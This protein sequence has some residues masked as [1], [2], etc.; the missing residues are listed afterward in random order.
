MAKAQ[1]PAH[2]GF[3]C[4]I[5]MG[6]DLSHS[7]SPLALVQASCAGVTQCGFNSLTIG[8]DCAV[9]LCLKSI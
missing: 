5:Y 3:S 7:T 2:S 4:L 9:I 1:T 8:H 6:I